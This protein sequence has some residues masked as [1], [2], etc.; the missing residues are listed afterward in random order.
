M[1]QLILDV[2]GI[3]VMLPESQK[4]GYTTQRE[5]LGE[6]VVMITGRLAKEIRGT[7]WRIT[8]QY[9]YFDDTTKQRVI[10]ACEKGRRAPIRCSFLHPT[11]DGESLTTSKF[12]VTAFNYPRF[13]WGR[14]QT[15]GTAIPLWGDF[16]LELREVEPSD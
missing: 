3:N 2:G 7:V 14:N 12:F 4:G 10:E 15:D 1:T 13:F 6:E 11:S 5:D 16:S 9:G 8:Y